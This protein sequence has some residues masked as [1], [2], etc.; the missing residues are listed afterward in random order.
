MSSDNQNSGFFSELGKGIKISIIISLSVYLTPTFLENIEK[1]VNKLNINSIK[2]KEFEISFYQ[3][4]LNDV[5][6]NAKN[7]NITKEELTKQLV[8]IKEQGAII[9]NPSYFVKWQ[10][11]YKDLSKTNILKCANLNLTKEEIKNY[12]DLEIN[13]S[14][15]T[16]YI[17]NEFRLLKSIDTNTDCSAS[18]LKP[19]TIY[20]DTRIIIKEIYKTDSSYNIIINY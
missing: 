1:F 19:I 20:I 2:T 17:N 3:Q 10:E 9:S 4:K 6:I 12:L 11:I 14:K 16:S 8:D 13:D 7:D 18:Y 5:V 15:L